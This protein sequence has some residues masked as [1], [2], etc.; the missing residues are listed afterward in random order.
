MTKLT[1]HIKYL[2]R[3]KKKLIILELNKGKLF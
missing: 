2:C 1:L 3:N